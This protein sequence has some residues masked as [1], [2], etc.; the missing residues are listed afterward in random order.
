MSQHPTIPASYLKAIQDE[1]SKAFQQSLD[2][3]VSL[4]NIARMVEATYS[5]EG[6]D[7]KL[8]EC[9][10]FIRLAAYTR[11]HEGGTE[12]LRRYL[13]ESKETIKKMGR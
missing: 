4:D 9:R 8:P 1:L 10:E 3:Q 13:V 2:L 6:F 7:L 5:R 11:F 12:R